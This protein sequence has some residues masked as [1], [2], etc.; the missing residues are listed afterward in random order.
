MKRH[1]KTTQPSL[2]ASVVDHM[3]K[4]TL[5][6]NALRNAMLYGDILPGD[7]LTILDL[8]D[9]LNMSQTPVREA[10]RILQTEG[11]IEQLPHH[12]ITVKKFSERDITDIFT[13]RARLESLA[14]GQSIPMMSDQH[15]A[16]LEKMHT[17]FTA[18]CSMCDYRT[19]Y[20]INSDWHNTLYSISGNNI[21]LDIIQRLWQRFLFG[22][23]W[24]VPGHPEHSLADHNAL[25]EAIRNRH[26]QL[27]C[28]LMESHIQKVRQAAIIF[29]QDP[30]RIPS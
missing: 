13:L 5:A 10:V 8:A 30:H 16:E 15:L 22:A 17:A 12:V 21:L 27:A 1:D 4:T 7:T 6:V 24:L 20:H 14:T 3:T 25:M 26:V 19:M 18:A 11:L 29:M 9:Q 28:D 23:F 2:S